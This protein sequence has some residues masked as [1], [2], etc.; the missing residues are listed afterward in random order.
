MNLVKSLEFFDPK[1]C[2]EYINIIGC[3]ATGST[4][5]ELLVRFGLTK[6]RLYD[7]D[8]VE[9]KNIANQ[10][11]R[12][13]DIGKK[14]VEALKDI[15]C[16][17]NPDIETKLKLFDK[18]WSKGM[19][20]EGYVFLCVDNIEVHQDVVAENMYNT[21]IKAIF[22]QRLSL[23]EGQHYAAD[24]S[25]LEH[26]KNLI[27]SQNFTHEEALEATPR[28]GCNEIL[29]VAPTIRVICNYAVANFINFVKDGNIK[30]LVISHAFDFESM[31]F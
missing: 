10:M 28:G 16:E 3:G 19:K 27:E 24:W 5:A 13:C 7:M 26:K 2:N 1:T 14:K 4:I 22:D 21:N 29:S 23:T 15:L 11:Y 25:I 30:V 12:Y 18:G 20:L 9:E 6:I 8:I 17:I 31:G